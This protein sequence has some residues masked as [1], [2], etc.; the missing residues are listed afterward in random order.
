[1]ETVKLL[2]FEN[3]LGN[4]EEGEASKGLLSSL[5]CHIYVYKYPGQP[6]I[7]IP[8]SSLVL[9]SSRGSSRVL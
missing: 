6:R 3:R 4:K 1:M 8:G 2:T 7:Y 9:S 5:C